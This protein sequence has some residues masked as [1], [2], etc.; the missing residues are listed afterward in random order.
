MINLHN[1]VGASG[2]TK[3]DSTTVQHDSSADNLKG[4]LAAPNNTDLDWFFRSTGDVLDAINAETVTT[5]P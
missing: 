2:T 5:V 1:G 4:S 3:L